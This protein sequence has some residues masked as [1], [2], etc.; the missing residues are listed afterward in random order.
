MRRDRPSCEWDIDRLDGGRQ[1]V[2]LIIGTLIFKHAPTHAFIQD[3]DPASALDGMARA[4]L[5]SDGSA[6]TLK[7]ARSFWVRLLLARTFAQ[8]NDPVRTPVRKRFGR[9]LASAAGVQKF[10]QV[11]PLM[12]GYAEDVTRQYSQIILGRPPLSVV[13]KAAS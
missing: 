9:I 4:G 5:I 3:V 10:D 11:R 12:R 2:E 6:N 1:D 8:W 13:S 7:S